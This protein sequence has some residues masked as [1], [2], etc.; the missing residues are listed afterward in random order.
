MAAG[1]AGFFTLLAALAALYFL[2][3]HKSP[4]H[5]SPDQPLRKNGFRFCCGATSVGRYPGY[6]IRSCNDHSGRQQRVV[7]PHTESYYTVG[8]S[9][10]SPEN[11]DKFFNLLT[12]K[13]YHPVHLGLTGN[14]YL[15][16]IDSFATERKP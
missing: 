4:L 3:L 15:V 5:W 6:P 14:F 2:F 11:A 10:K 12:A 1:I 8:G 9:F 16:A 13:G 7:I